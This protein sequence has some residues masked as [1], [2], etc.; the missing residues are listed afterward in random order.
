MIKNKRL[1]GG[2]M[3]RRIIVPQLFNLLHDPVVSPSWSTV[4]DMMLAVY[5]R[6]N[7]LT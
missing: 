7:R 4:T 3:A 1:T 6:A 5:D 2:F